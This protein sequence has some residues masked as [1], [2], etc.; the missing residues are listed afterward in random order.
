[1]IVGT[2]SFLLG[3]LFFLAVQ[4]EKSESITAQAKVIDYK[5]HNSGR[6][7]Y[8]SILEYQNDRGETVQFTD[9][10]RNYSPRHELGEEVEILYIPNKV[11]TE[12]INT[13]FSIYFLPAILLFFGIGSVIFGREFYKN[14]IDFKNKSK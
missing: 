13:F 10:I 5:T 11:H 12:K 2:V 1:M 3:I 8:Q 9:E 7:E 4:S 14:K 6:T